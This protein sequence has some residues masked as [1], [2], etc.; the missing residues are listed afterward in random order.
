MA[1][2]SQVEML[3]VQI[4]AAPGLERLR[5][6]NGLRDFDAEVIVAM[7]SEALRFATEKLAPFDSVADREGC[8][9]EAGRV[10]LATG[11]RELWHD[12]R[13]AG[14]TGL[15]IAAEYG[16][17]GLPRILATAVQECFD[18]ASV[19]FGMVPGSARAASRLLQQHAA[20]AVAKAWISKLATGEWAATICISESDA[21]SDVGRIRTSARRTAKGSWLISGEKMWISYADHDLT[22]RIG[23]IVLA[24]PQGAA[25]GIRG[26]SLFLVASVVDAPNGIGARNRVAVRRIEEKMGLHGSPTCVLGFEDAEA[27]M[28]GLEG[29]GVAQLFSM[30][31]AMRLQVG[32]QGLGFAESSY[33]AAFSYAR[34]R[35]QGGPSN[36]PPLPIAAHA[37]VQVSLM[38]MASRIAT[39]RGLVYAGAIAGDLADAETDADARKRAAV[40]QAW[41]LPIIKNSG[42]ETGFNVAADSILLF[43]GA[44]YTT[45]WPVERYLRDSRVLAIY[46][47]TAGMQALD[48]VRRRWREPATGFEAFVDAVNTDLMTMSA[49]LFEPLRGALALLEKASGWLRASEREDWEIEAAARPLLALATEVAHGWIGA[50]LAALAGTDLAS[51]QI[52][53]FGRHAL[54]V[55]LERAAAA[56]VA[57]LEAPMRK[58]NCAALGFESVF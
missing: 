57:V 14:W 52:A 5:A 51:V 45:E 28:I 1:F 29:R 32:T 31:V 19:T 39:L 20:P 43:G 9:L 16:G 13:A 23:H 22:E 2:D 30:I 33:R 18:R 15:D 6:I 3:M 36:A 10:V 11:H 8:R 17:Q 50:R 44:G 7:L 46:E 40:L 4:N 49:P 21:G 58:K 41:L 27:E 35:R 38:G 24:R 47:G 56:L 54:S 26:L 55:L 12:Y 37:D 42:A 48:L 53:V 25:Q 34:Q